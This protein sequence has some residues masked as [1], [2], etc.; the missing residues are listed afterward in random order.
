M[1]ISIPKASM[2]EATTVFS[3]LQAVDFK[4]LGK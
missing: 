2:D 3:S 4:K 1:I